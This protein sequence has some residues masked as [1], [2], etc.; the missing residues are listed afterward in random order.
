MRK[1]HDGIKRIDENSICIARELDLTTELVCMALMLLRW[2]I[3]SNVDSHS[4][5]SSINQCALQPLLDE[6]PP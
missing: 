6:P 5:D 4:K 3:A 1:N 2:R